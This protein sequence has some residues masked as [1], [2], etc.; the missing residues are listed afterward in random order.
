[1]N[2]L[3]SSI[4]IVSSLVAL[5][6]LGGCERDPN[7]E[8]S[9]NAIRKIIS[10]N[11]G[12]QWILTDDGLHCFN[13]TNWDDIQNFPVGNHYKFVNGCLNNNDG[14]EIW[15]AGNAGSTMFSLGTNSVISK[16]NVTSS[17]S[18]LVSDSVSA[19]AVDFNNIKY[20]GT[21]KGI[22][23]NEGENWALFSGRENEEIL[24]EFEITDIATAKNGWVYAS[25]YGGGVSRFKYTDAVSG[26]TLFD[27]VWSQMK[28]NY[29]NTVIIVDDTCQFYGT[30]RGASLHTNEYTKDI[31]AW[32]SYTSADGLPSDTVMAIAK[33]QD[34]TVWF[35]TTAGL[36]RL[37]GD[38]ITSFTTN[39]GLI[40]NRIKT[41]SI[42][43]EGSIWIGTEKGISLYKNGSFTTVLVGM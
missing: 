10:D 15:F 40:S 2:L 32:H 36:A 29:V 11:A 26:A 14:N 31:E 24:S 20:F 37:S 28:S 13:G 12:L 23:I 3:K 18:E 4:Y 39:D 19:V 43:K 6:C 42:D 22:S 7:E 38:Q 30:N 1:M 17:S 25:T 21:A 33:E 16:T 9:S 35:G 41:I 8:P 5:L 34:G 27:S